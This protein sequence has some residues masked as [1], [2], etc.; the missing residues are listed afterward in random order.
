MEFSQCGD[1]RAAASGAVGGQAAR[2]LPL[3]LLLKDKRAAD[4]IC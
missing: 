1:M 2:L 4:L 3:V